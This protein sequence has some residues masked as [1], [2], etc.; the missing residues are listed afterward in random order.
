[1]IH[2]VDIYLVC[3]DIDVVCTFHQD[4]FQCVTQIHIFIAFSGSSTPF[5]K[6]LLLYVIGFV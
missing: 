4:V 1:M 5:D 6:V 2:A 3:V